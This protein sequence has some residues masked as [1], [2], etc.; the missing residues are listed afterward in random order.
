LDDNFVADVDDAAVHDDS[1]DPGLPH[2]VAVLVVVQYGGEKS[3]L[4]LLQLRAGI[5]KAGD[6]YDGLAAQTKPSPGRQ[7]EKVDSRRG[8]VLAHLAGRDV[9]AGSV[10]LR[11]ELGVYQVNLPQ[12]WLAWIPSHAGKVLDCCTGVRVSLDA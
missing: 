7:P 11:V 6:L 1:H 10:E 2:Q 8:N 12:I 9:Q 3:G 5:T 4:D